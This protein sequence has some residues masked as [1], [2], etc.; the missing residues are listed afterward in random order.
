MSVTGTAADTALAGLGSA[1][2]PRARVVVTLR[3]G[4]R[5]A[6]VETWLLWTDGAEP[7][8][9][10]ADHV[11]GPA[12]AGLWRRAPWPVRDEVFELPP[13][14]GEVPSVLVVEGDPAERLAAVDALR[15]RGIAAVEAERLNLE[16]LTNASL[17]VLCTRNG[18]LPAS[19]MAPL[20]AGRL[21]VTVACETSFGLLPGIDH[22]AATEARLAATLVDAALTQWDAFAPMRALGRIAAE[23][24]RASLVYERL[25][26]DLELEGDDE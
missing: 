21:V 26:A 25:L 19:G 7:A 11:L 10:D 18:A 6:G 2:D 5:P 14:P 15:E 4:P 12:G 24:H 9:A 16:V 1:G 8:G 17:V 13:P 20:A 3:A 23:R 22:L